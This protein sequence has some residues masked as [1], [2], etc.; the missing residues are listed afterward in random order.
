M[1][2]GTRKQI[3]IGAVLSYL[4]I[5]VQLASGLVYT[6]IVLKSL[7]KSQYGVYSLCTSFMGYLTIM[8]SGANAA[9][10]RFYVQTKVK[11]PKKVP[12][13]NGIFLKIFSVLALIALLGGWTAGA[14]SPAI[15]GDKISPAEYDIVKT[16][17][18]FLAVS[19]A[20]QIINCVF[21]SLIIA[22][23]RFIF[24][25]VINLIA[26]IMSPVLTTPFL[27]AGYSCVIIIVIHLVTMVFTLIFNIV[28][29]FRTIK[30]SFS[31][32]ENDIVLLKDIAQ[33]AGFIVLQSIMDQVNWQIDKFILARTHGTD[34]ISIYSV[35]STF[36]K[37]YIT[38]SSAISGV[39]I[40]QVN[41]LQ[42]VKDMPK[43]NDLFIRSSRMFA[44][45]IWLFM[46][47]FIILG[48]PFVLRWAGSGYE[49]SYAIGLMLMLP[50]TASL[51]MG[52]AQD[53]A[54]AMNKHQLQIV[55]NFVICIVNG[56]VSI[57]LAIR[58]RATGS[59]FG[60]FVAEI[61]MCLIAEPL[62]YKKILG[63]E[64]KKLLVQVGRIIPGLVMPLIFGIIVTY[65]H[66]IQPDY[67]NIFAFAIVY[68][69]IYGVSMWMFAFDAVEKS[70]VKKVLIKARNILWVRKKTDLN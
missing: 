16:C 48:K 13:L 25:K 59:A 34:E 60:T 66:V 4:V 49:D 21:S 27:L 14:F 3:S 56:I 15:F 70:M 29:C 30:V 64:M 65:Y 6:P 41:K 33:F 44:Y 35:G 20:V 19:S 1:D 24:S 61:C 37:Y 46:S 17:F 5:L 68:L 39:F 8:N 54:R 58:W 32:K 28:Y 7:G 11:D 9:Y 43:M 67:A 50:V 12:G 47:A 63:L 51:T 62:Y 55:I 69:I 57:P 22:N 36:N 45:F 42:A 40:A 2:G 38:F 26:A 52:L 18:S 23:E 53:I 10:I 31:L